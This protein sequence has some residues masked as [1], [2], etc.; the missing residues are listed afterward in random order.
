KN[1]NPFNPF[2]IDVNKPTH[3]IGKT[4]SDLKFWQNTGGTIIGIRRGEKLYLSPGPYS[5][6][7]KGDVLIIV[8][9]EDVMEKTLKFLYEN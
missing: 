1:I 7:N 8:G 2:E 4:I 6:I 9:D 3:A 5:E